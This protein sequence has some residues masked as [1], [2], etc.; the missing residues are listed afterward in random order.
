MEMI[1]EGGGPAQATLPRTSP[2]LTAFPIPHEGRRVLIPASH[3][4]C[5]AL[6]MVAVQRTPRDDALDELGHVES[7]GVAPLSW[8]GNR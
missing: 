6:G 8:T 4:L 5:R 2:P 3:D 7:G 1:G